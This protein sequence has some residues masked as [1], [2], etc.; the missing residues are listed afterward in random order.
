MYA[1][2][3]IRGRWT[4]GRDRPR[5]GRAAVVEALQRIDEPF[6]VVDVEGEPAVAFGG[7]VR[8]GGSADGLP[9]YAHVPAVPVDALGDASFNAD[10]G[11]RVAYTTGAMANGIASVEVVSA[12]GR[13]GGL[14]FFGAAGLGLPRIRDAVHRLK[15]D[16]GA[17]PW[18]VN[19]IHSP[20]EPSHEQGVVDLL[21]AEGVRTVEASAFLKLQPTLV[22]YRAR[23]L[24]E[25]PDGRVRIANRVVAKVS[26]DEVAV[27][28][29]RPAPAAMLASLVSAG[30]ITEAQARLAAR[31]P[32][33]DDLTA[34]ADSGGHTDNRPSLVLIPVLLAMRDR[35]ARETGHVV[36]IGAAGGIATPQAVAAAFATGASYVMTGTVNQAC[37]E[38]GTSAMARALLA[39]AGFADVDMAPAS[40]MF[41]SG[42]KVQV[43]K[44]GTMFSR[45]AE[46]LY[47]TWRAYA[48]IDAIPADERQK[49]ESQVLRRPIEAIWADCESFFAERDPAQLER[50]AREPKHRMA[51][52]FRWYL[53]MSSRWA[54]G[55]DADRKLDMQVWCGPAIGAFNEWT[56][57][58]FLADP[59]ERRVVVV[60]ANLLAGAAA[61]T[62]ARILTLQGVDPGP[63][64]FAFAPRPVES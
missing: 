53:G 28:F 44:R 61:L 37:V 18:G 34:E 32:V 26:R 2:P 64:A 36:R 15:A 59:A 30:K 57:G 33:A 12:I 50:A 35:V 25:G 24:S 42:V 22:Q 48:S 4:P 27:Q 3:A 55:G 54:I 46:K 5:K 52:V 7:E 38:S 9:V 45:R 1:R 21:L 41:E 19:L 58:T 10:Y 16:L 13:G 39:D 56:R 11:T 8:L 14:G 62:R 23:G 40:D 60:A 47:D 63:E 20:Q 17:L 51:L 6:A 29:A 31:V 49:L 43:L